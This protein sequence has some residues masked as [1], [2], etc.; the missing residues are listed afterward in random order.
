MSRQMI[1]LYGGPDDGLQLPLEGVPMFELK[2][3]RGDGS[4]VDTYRLAEIGNG[5]VS[6]VHY[7]TDRT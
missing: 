6:Y 7:R 3:E 2:R 4:A 1:T 5:Y